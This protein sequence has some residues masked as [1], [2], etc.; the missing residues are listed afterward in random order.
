MTDPRTAGRCLVLALALG[1]GLGL[2]YG[3]LCVLGRRHRHLADVLFLPFLFYTWVYLSFAIC[4][5]DLRL[6][7]TL[8]LFAGIFLEE[9]T[10]GRRLRPLY[11]RLW[12][13]L[14]SLLK[15]ILQKMK[16]FFKKLFPIRKKS[17]TIE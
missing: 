6:G 2:I 7:Y 9:N 1:M 11:L 8:G 13:F 17:G 16:K 12:R 3:L 15:K 10:L 14:H 4:R 5:G